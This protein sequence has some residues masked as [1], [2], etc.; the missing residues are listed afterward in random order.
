MRP[1]ITMQAVTD[2]LIAYEQWVDTQVMVPYEERKKACFIDGG[3]VTHCQK[4]C[5]RCCDLLVTIGSLDALRIGRYLKKNGM[6]TKEL[7][8]SLRDDTALVYAMSEENKCKDDTTLANIYFS[9][10]RPC[11]F[12]KDGGCS[13][14]EARPVVCRLFNSLVPREECMGEKRGE[15]RRVTTNDLR[16]T[17][18]KRQEEYSTLTWTPPAKLMPEIVLWA[19]EELDAMEARNA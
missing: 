13:I 18:G 19:L 2:S 1:G 17:A 15:A 10:K 16:L 6:D 7:R 12:V 11:R 3:H 4:G 9:N 8:D 14:Y 5:T